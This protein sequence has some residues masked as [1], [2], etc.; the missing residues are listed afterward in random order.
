MS[1][2]IVDTITRHAV[3]AVSR[4]ASVLAVGGMALATVT[5]APSAAKGGKKRRQ[6]AARSE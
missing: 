6:D 3:G 2:P 5:A 4:R 1:A